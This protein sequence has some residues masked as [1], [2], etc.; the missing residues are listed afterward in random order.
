MRITSRKTALSGLA[1]LG[2]SA[3]LLAG[4]AA[5]PTD[6]SDPGTDPGA[7]DFKP[8]MVSDSGGFDDKSFNQLGKEGLD[9]ASAALGVTGNAVESQAETDYPSNI[10]GL[11][12]DGCNIIVTV[13]FLLAAATDTAAQA[14]PDVNF[15]IIDDSSIDLAN[16]K[17]IVF[18]TAQAAFLAGYAAASYTK[19][20]I[21]GTFGGIPIP[22]VTIFMDGFYEGVMHY[23]EVKGTSVQ[24]LGWDIAKQDEGAFTGG[25]EANDTAKSTAQNLIDQ[26]ADVILPVG[27][28]IFLSAGEAI[29]DSGKDIALIGVDAD[30]YVT[31]PDLSDL[32]LTSIMKGI[33]VGVDEVV[34]T[35]AAGNFDNSPFVGTLEN[36]GVG[37]ADFH[38]FASK[39]DPGLQAELDALKAEII[40][41][42]ITLNS[43]SSPR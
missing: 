21:V 11:V 9:K 41:G 10:N 42:A 26:N 27:G 22:P 43:P 30:V 19:T 8:C 13:G 24:V 14:N 34:T 33:A 7:T 15:A 12:D 2:T 28:P 17:P 6:P 25:F 3:L 32:F 29:R 4:C 31:S 39:V 16:V 18:D 5:A 36:G 20:G 38:D 1:V 23:N 35:A 37:I 40:S